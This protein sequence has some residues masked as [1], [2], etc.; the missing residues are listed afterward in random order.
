MKRMD[1]AQFFE[2]LAGLD[3][4]CL[5]RTLWNLYWRG[6]ATTRERIENELEPPP[7][8][9][10]A[11]A[12]EESIDPDLLSDEVSHF[13]ELVHAGAY[14]GRDRRVHPRERTR[15]R[16]TFRHL[17]SDAESALGDH[18]VDTAARAMEQLIDLAC[19]TRRYDYFRSED[20]V[21]AARFV[22]SDAAALLWSRVLERHGFAVFAERAA[23]QFIRWESRCG[24]T[25]SGAGAIG[26]KETSLAFVLA[27]MLPALDMWIRFTDRYLAALDR[28]AAIAGSRPRPT[29]E[30]TSLDRRLRAADLA[31]WDGLLLD[32]LI[33]SEAEDRLDKLARH[34]VLR[35]PEL[36]YFEAR[37][38]RRRGDAARARILVHQALQ[39][40]PGHSEFLR[41][42]IE[43]GA[44]LPPEAARAAGD[45][46]MCLP[47]E[48]PAGSTSDLPV[49]L[50]RSEP[51][52]RASK[53]AKNFGC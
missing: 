27:R 39:E 1:R 12:R 7:Q 10:D 15:W 51:P 50:R 32:R 33:G 34:A 22:V 9:R 18:D 53:T 36:V 16:F 23:P 28:I 43:I 6:S 11:R 19:D 42:A 8:R 41:F 47:D 17:A 31:E 21:E 35:G 13:V 44:T 3:D 45:R 29:W 20:P 26:K 30:P 52:R 37:L 5:K 25:R 4:E 48:A 38:A 14:L 40:L 46:G 2:K 24:W 49:A